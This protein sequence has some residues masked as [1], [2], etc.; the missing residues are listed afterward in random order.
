MKF[1]SR[2]DRYNKRKGKQIWK[3]WCPFCNPNE[4]PLRAGKYWHIVYNQYP[5]T[6]NDQH[7][8]AVPVRHI[9]FSTDFTKSE[10]KELTSVYA[11]AKQFF[12]DKSYF[13]FTRET[14]DC[15]SI[16]HYHT[17]FCAGQLQGRYLRKMLEIEGFPIYEDM[18][19]DL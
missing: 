9:V 18:K 6:G 1:L 14:I 13:S 5:Y 2:F 8:M 3:S 15:R 12:W 17:H 16:E 10:L 19:E 11:F 4:K 7:I